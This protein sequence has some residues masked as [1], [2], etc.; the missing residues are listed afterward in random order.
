MG[1]EYSLP[2]YF[3]HLLFCGVLWRK[4]RNL[5]MFRNDDVFILGTITFTPFC[6]SQPFIFP[7]CLIS[8]GWWTVHIL[9]NLAPSSH[10]T[11]EY[12]HHPYRN[13]KPKPKPTRKPQDFS[14]KINLQF[15]SS[16]QIEF[17]VLNSIIWG[18]GVSSGQMRGRTNGRA[19]Y[20][21]SFSS[22]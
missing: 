8:S 14:T 17:S 21:L 16:S 13:K 11:S 15:H 22:S 12:P 7:V 19:E 3:F 6:S 9:T 18:N 4:C 2:S 5:F 20:L 1:I 10:H